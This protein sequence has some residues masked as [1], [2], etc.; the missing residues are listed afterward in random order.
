MIAPLV[1]YTV[2]HTVCSEAWQCGGSPSSLN[3]ISTVSDH[4]VYASFTRKT[5]RHAITD[6]QYRRRF[7]KD[8]LRD[9]PHPQQATIESRT[10]TMSAAT[11]DTTMAA[12]ITASAIGT[13]SSATTSSRTRSRSTSA[14]WPCRPFT[15]PKTQSTF[16]SNI[17]GLL[18]ALALSIFSIV[19]IKKETNHDLS[20][21][22][23]LSA[24]AVLY[25]FKR[26]TMLQVVLVAVLPIFLA[27]LCFKDV[28]TE[29]AMLCL[30]CT[31]CAFAAG[32]LIVAVFCR[33]F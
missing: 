22:I 21:G 30:A 26:I 19:A 14:Y 8:Q 6:K 33:F 12:N 20:C 25:M 31:Q 28:A 4:L 17:H 5:S 32:C 29:A 1:A 10:S 13:R 15:R 2:S 23:W 24:A 18:L 27:A 16:I 7:T 9:T 11:R 3:N